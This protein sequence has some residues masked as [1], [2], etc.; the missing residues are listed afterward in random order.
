MSTAPTTAIVGI[1][2]WSPSITNQFLIYK[3]VS[4]QYNL[5]KNR[6]G[7]VN[8]VSAEKHGFYTTQDLVIKPTASGSYNRAYIYQGETHKDWWEFKLNS[9]QIRV[10]KIFN[11][12]YEIEVFVL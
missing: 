5:I 11:Y 3:V 4:G 8:N 12:D 9:G 1:A 10:D 6:N 2:T 7:D